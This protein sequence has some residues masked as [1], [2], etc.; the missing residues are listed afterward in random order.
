MKNLFV[1]SLLFLFA[2]ST[3]S[4]VLAASGSEMP[5]PGREIYTKVGALKIPFIKHEPPVE[6][7]TVKFSAATPAA[8]IFVENGAL[9]YLLAK[10]SEP[11]AGWTLREKPLGSKA[12]EVEGLSPSPTKVSLFKG[13][14]PR[15]WRVALPAFEEL[16]F[17]E[18]YDHIRLN[19]KAH[20]K[21]VEKIFI[22][23]NGG[24][25][26]RIA[27]QIEGA[28]RLSVNSEGELEIETGIGLFKMTA[29]IAYQEIDGQKVKVAA[30]YEL[31]AFEFQETDSRHVYGFKVGNYD[32]TK[33]LF[34]DPL[35]AW[36][37]V[38]GNQEDK[39]Y[40][41]ALDSDKNV[42][43]TGTTRSS[44]FPVTPGTYDDT[45]ESNLD[46]FVSKFDADLTTLVASTFIGGSGNDYGYS[47]AIAADGNIYIAG[48]TD[49]SDFP[50]TA[51]AY[52]IVKSGY[53]DTFVTKLTNDLSSLLASS[54]VGGSGNDYG[55]ALTIDSANKIFVTGYTDSTNFP[56]TA[57]AYQTARAGNE[58]AFIYKLNDALSSL[59]ASTYLGGSD[60]DYAYGLTKNG[61][62]SVVGA[63]ASADFPIVGGKY[64]ANAGELDAFIA[65][66][67]SNLTSI[68]ASTY[69]GGDDHDVGK[70]IAVSGDGDV[71][72]TGWTVSTAYYDPFP[73]TPTNFKEPTFPTTPGAYDRSNDPTKVPSH[74][75]SDVFVSKFSSYLSVLK[76]STLLGGYEGEEGNAIALDSFG[77][78]FVT[79]WTASEGDPYAEPVIPPFPTTQ[80]A[81]DSTLNGEEDVFVVQFDPNLGTLLSSTILGGESHDIAQGVTLDDEVNVYLAGSTY[82]DDFPRPPVFIPDPAY[83]Y[84]GSWDAFITKLTPDFL[85]QYLLSISKG[86]TGEG[87]VTSLPTGIDCGSTCQKPFNYNLKI[88]LTAAPKEN[89]VFDETSWTGGCI[90]EDPENKPWECTATMLSDLNIGVQFILK[91]YTIQATANTGGTISPTG[92]VTVQYGASQGFAITPDADSYLADVI[93][94][95]SSVTPAPPKYGTY[96]YTFNNV[97][98]NRT[99]QAVFRPNPVIQATSDQGGAILPTGAV[100]VQYGANLSFTITPNAGYALVDLLVNGESKLSAPKFEAYIYTMSNVTTDGTIRAVFR[101]NPVIQAT[102]NTGGTIS[103]DGAVTVQYDGSQSFAITPGAGFYLADVIVDGVSVSPTPPKYGTYPYTFTNVTSDRTIRA[104]FAPNPTIQATADQGGTILPT[105]AVMVQYGANQS[106]TITPNAGYALTDLLVDGASVLS[107]PQFTSYIHTLTNV[108]TDHAIRAVFRPNPVIATAANSG[109]TISPAGPVT[110]QYGGS[111]IFSITPDSGNYLADLIVDGVSVTP[112]PP[113]YGTYIHTFANVTS[114]RTIRAVFNPNPVVQTIADTGG[115]ILPLGPVTVQ[116]DG[117]QSFTITPNL[118]YALVDLLVDGVSV[119]TEPKYAAYTHVLS[120]ITTDRTIRAIFRSNPSIQTA[121]NAGGTISPVGPVTVQYGGDQNFSITPS[122]GYYLADVIVDG[123]SVVPAPPK[124]GTYIYTFSNVTSDRT[125]RVVFNPNPVIQTVADPGGTILPVGPVTVQYGATQNFTITPNAGYALA[126]LLVDGVSV[127]AEPKY[128]SYTHTLTNIVSD[129]TIRAIFRPNPLIQTT[130]S[131]G[132]T[133]SPVGPVTVQYGGSQSFSITPNAGYYL[134]DVMVDGNSVTPS[135]PKYGTYVLTLTNVTSD[136]TIRAVFQPNPLIETTA[137]SGGAIFPVGPVSVQYGESITFTINPNSGY[138]ILDVIVDGISKGPLSTWT[139]TNVTSDRSIRAVF[140]PSPV[141]RTIA[142]TGGTIFPPGPLTIN[143]GGNQ[144]FTIIPDAGYYI[145]DVLVN[146]ASVG[147]VSTY[148]FTDVTSDQTIRAIFRHHPVIKASVSGGGTISPSGDVTVTHG[149]NQSFSIAPNLG[150]YLADVVVDG[151]S[152]LPAP[153]HYGTYTYSFTNVTSD[154]TIMAVFRPEPTLAIIQTTG[155][156]IYPDTTLS[157]RYGSD[158]LISVFPDP[159]YFLTDVIID[160]TSIGPFAGHWITDIREDHSVRAI[161]TQV[162]PKTPY[163]IIATA[164]PGGT[165]RPFGI[166]NV[167]PLKSKTFNIKAS[168][169]YH[170]SDVIVDGLSKGPIPKYSFQSVTASHTIEAVFDTKKTLTIGLQGTGRGMVISKPLGISCGKDCTEDYDTG[171]LVLLIPRPAADSVF[172]GWSGGGCKGTDTCT[173]TMDDDV[174]VIATFT[175]K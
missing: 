12:T 104:V 44:G 155:G 11:K 56:T 171:E 62:V 36:T 143:Y 66:L 25:P 7:D 76:A 148:T 142:D 117:T 172:V 75:F 126:D 125:I 101:S 68:V 113:K 166:Q 48:D 6:D 90:V 53:R 135:P 61:D 99:I 15:N 169:G 46:I 37:F 50:T 110:V 19:V 47:I 81:Y 91:T 154:R 102:A 71:Y 34:I 136:R 40:A 69:L 51:G 24:T 21:N 158:L 139:F 105:G 65:R 3:G 149:G 119:L 121:V 45:Y 153:P 28:R 152:V 80:G 173:V 85:T 39:A 97:T 27:L 14:D 146:G 5:P 167:K 106:F 78:V 10:K 94:D 100:M 124:Y 42:F 98:S 26:E 150:Y 165:I 132:G 70:A 175:L 60:S 127:L 95:G 23:E 108:T 1:F 52:Q 122:A 41:I 67:D 114:D 174:T 129:R 96:I 54:F 115:S 107:E 164:G 162:M 128:T 103:P 141:I 35:L 20:G 8:T 18:I 140:R 109:G 38:G 33:P 170:I 157:V 4:P 84:S 160:G 145:Y 49:S 120:N 58:D 79:G 63:T 82:S 134:G 131:A 163:T 111:Q 9:T 161:F 31:K 88:K 43:V 30:A 73:P 156:T 151:N 137:D 55:R 29:P 57:G 22:V 32:N 133:I 83:E 118:G 168:K 74:R 138:S 86:G 93:V 159:G 89:S 130:V 64:P 77:N 72:V 92:S 13:K 2:I 123:V 87:T 17:G 112:A 59:V 16:T 116:Y 144:S 147:A